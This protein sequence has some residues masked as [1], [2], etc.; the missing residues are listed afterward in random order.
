MTRRFDRA[1]AAVVTSLHA[2]GAVYMVHRMPDTRTPREI[3]CPTNSY[4]PLSKDLPTFDGHVKTYI[5]IEFAHESPSG[6]SKQGR[7]EKKQRVE[8]KRNNKQM[9]T[10]RVQPLHE[11]DPFQ[12]AKFLAQG[13]L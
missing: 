8:G 6:S 10:E 9:V 1:V 3:Q 7:G 12:C 13:R 5:K 4:N 11:E 2:V